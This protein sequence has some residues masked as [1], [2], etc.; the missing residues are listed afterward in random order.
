MAARSVS[1]RMRLRAARPAEAV[2]PLHSGAH[3]RPARSDSL[4]PPGISLPSQVLRAL[5]NSSAA[6]RTSRLA[7]S[8]QPA[9]KS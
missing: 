8:C 1:S 3:E 9:A 2:T 4:R 7:S 6:T 5:M